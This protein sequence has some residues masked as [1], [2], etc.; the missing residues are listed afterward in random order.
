MI[1]RLRGLPWSKL[2]LSAAILAIFAPALLLGRYSYRAARGL[3]TQVEASLVATNRDVT[4][5]VIRA[6][7]KDIITT[8]HTMFELVDFANLGDLEMRW[9]ENARALEAVEAVAVLDSPTH[10]VQYVSRAK[11]AAEREQFRQLLQSDVLAELQLEGVQRDAHMHWHQRY[12]DQP[13]LLSYTRRQSPVPGD[14][15]YFIVLRVSTRH[16][17]DAIFPAEFRPLSRSHRFAVVNNQGLLVYGD[18]ELARA[19][20][21]FLYE[22]HFPTTLW[23]WRVQMAPRDVEGL[24]EQARVRRVLD[25]TIVSASVVILM[26]GVLVLLWAVRK[27]RRAN[28]LK[29]EFIANVSHELKTPLSLIRMFAELVAMGKT[30]GE[31]ATREYAEIIT[32]E[33][34]RL[35]RLID[36]VLDFARIER[37]KAAYEFAPGDL[38]EVI[39][40]GLDLY[41]HRLDREKVR[42]DAQLRHDLPQVRMDEN[43]LTLALLNLLENAVKYGGGSDITVRVEASADRVDLVVSDRGPGVPPEEQQ[44]IWERFYRGK[45]H[46]TRPIRGSGIGLALVRH[47]AEAH[48]GQALVV[49]TPGGGATFIIRLPVERHDGSREPFAQEAAAHRG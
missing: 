6:V 15:D 42:L 49:S 19:A 7:E 3:A 40:R 2:A 34:D 45:A 43:A 37:G 35:A 17:L 27:E 25:I 26:F 33:S 22:R 24:L 12:G 44:R 41:R 30:R 47:I 28:E 1:E 38:A 13:V 18:R 29:S 5:Q 9:E 11:T 14:R 20:G 46:R 4:D 48:G 36:N 16:L 8:D 39:E 23:Q 32:R 31:D 21:G 10:V